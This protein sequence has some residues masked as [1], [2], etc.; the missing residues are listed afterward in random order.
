M[1]RSNLGGYV[2]VFNGA[3]KSMERLS[4]SRCGAFLYDKDDFVEQRDYGGVRVIVVACTNCD[5][6]TEDE[7]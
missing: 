7:I 3:A 5:F 1:G 6:E 4:C 2:R